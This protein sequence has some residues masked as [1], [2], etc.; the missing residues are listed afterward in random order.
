M[1]LHSKLRR[2]TATFAVLILTVL[3]STMA[4]TSAASAATSTVDY[5]LP[6]DGSVVVAHATATKKVP[7]SALQVTINCTLSIDN[8]H[9]SN[10]V[11]SNW[12]VHLN[13]SCTAPVAELSASPRLFRNG[14]IVD[15]PLP[16]VNTGKA[17]L[18]AV[19]NTQCDVAGIFDTWFADGQGTAFFPAGF[20][21]PE[22]TL[23]VQS[24]NILQ[25]LDCQ[26]P[27]AAPPVAV[28]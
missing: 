21:P 11:P 28:R 2:T 27:P 15:E 6:H 19:A 25:G 5:Q 4:T 22:I 24:G 23:E 1:E 9:E 26:S 14:E 12:N 3:G 18:Q 10:T 20:Q 7:L 17:N 8:P 16:S 13:W